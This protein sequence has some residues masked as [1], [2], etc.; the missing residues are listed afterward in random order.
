MCEN[1]TSPYNLS[2]V[3]VKTAHNTRFPLDNLFDDVVYLR[4]LVIRWRHVTDKMDDIVI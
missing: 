4:L 2:A 3:Q 1:S